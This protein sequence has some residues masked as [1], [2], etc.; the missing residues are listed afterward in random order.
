M[1][2]YL[3]FMYLSSLGLPFFGGLP[4]IFP[5]VVWL[6]T[7]VF[8]LKVNE[9]LKSHI[10]A[11]AKLSF[12]TILAV[13]LLAFTLQILDGMTAMEAADK[14]VSFKFV[15]FISVCILLRWYWY[16]A[17]GLITLKRF[18]LFPQRLPLPLSHN[19]LQ[20][21]KQSVAKSMTESKEG[22]S[23]GRS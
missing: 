10:N 18:K 19:R 23:N 11:T 5:I 2:N 7:F 20:M 21:L 6:F 13:I 3:L 8:N 12:T 16:S 9:T 22:L 14:S 4:L 17:I 1:R 15:T